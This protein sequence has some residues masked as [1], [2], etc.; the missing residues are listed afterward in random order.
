VSKSVV[1][2]PPS[3]GRATR[4]L[5]TFRSRSA[6]LAGFHGSGRDRLVEPPRRNGTASNGAPTEQQLPTPVREDHT[7]G[8]TTI[9]AMEH[10]LISGLLQVLPEPG[11]PLSAERRDAWLEAFKMNM[12]FIWPAEASPN[13]PVRPSVQ[14]QSDAQD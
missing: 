12:Q 8:P 1:L 9:K 10:P 11:E 4:Y 2:A 14:S 7:P 13:E 6:E 3:R 5:R